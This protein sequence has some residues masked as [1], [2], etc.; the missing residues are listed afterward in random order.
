MP[1]GELGERL[2]PFLDQ[3]GYDV[4]RGPSPL[5]VAVL[6]RERAATLVEMAAA[7][8]YFY[9]PPAPAPELVAR[10]VNDG[11]RPALAELL[12]AMATVEWSREALGTL[13]KSAAARHGLKPPQLMMAL[14]ALVAGSTQ[15]PAID[16]VLALVGRAATR[17]RMSAG[18]GPR[19]GE[20]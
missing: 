3:A 4:A 18:L 1:A 16:A 20:A 9:G 6:L 11:I 2:R 19:T 8:A 14:R 7:A 5:D 12:E 10:H 13:I 15:T 17:E